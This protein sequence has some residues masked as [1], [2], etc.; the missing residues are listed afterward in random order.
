MSGKKKTRGTN[1]PGKNAGVSHRALDEA[2]KTKAAL[3]ADIGKFKMEVINAVKDIME[4]HNAVAAQAAAHD[5]MI[6]NV[7]GFVAGKLGEANGGLEARFISI[8]KSI[9]GVDVNVLAI[10]EMLKELVGQLTQIDALISNLHKQTSNLLSSNWSALSEDGKYKQ[11]TEEDFVAYKKALELSADDVADIKSN[12]ETW[13]KELLTSAFRSAQESMRD[14]E[15]AA[16]AAYEAEQKRAKE[17]AEKAAAAQREQQALEDECKKA[18]ADEQSLTAKTS[19]G[20]GSPY[21]EGAE[22]FGG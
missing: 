20:Q 2:V 3:I 16:D 22:I 17:A 13:Y 6:Q 7:V 9:R 10:G 19:G 12:A 18:A 15:R 21:P 11:L 8:A 5:Q 4:K 1:K 14:Q